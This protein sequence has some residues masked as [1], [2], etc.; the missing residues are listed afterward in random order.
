M[1]AAGRSLLWP[2]ALLLV[3][4][5]NASPGWA[6]PSTCPGDCNGDGQVMV[7]ELITLVNIAL[8][9]APLA[10]C[11]AGDVNR[12]GVIT[13]DDVV[14]AV[15]AALNGCPPAL[16]VI[17]LGT[18]A[19]F[20]GE[21]VNLSIM[22][23]SNGH[24]TLSIA[25]LVF[26]FE[27]AALSV[28]DCSSAVLG[29]S[30]A[31]QQLASGQTL[32]SLSGGLG[33]IADGIVLLCRL[34]IADGAAA[35]VYPLRFTS[36]A[37]LD[38]DLSNLAAAGMDG[39]VTVLAQMPTTSPTLTA[40]AS[41]PPSATETPPPTASR[42]ATPSASPTSS[43]T[44]PATPSPTR[45]LTGTS[46][47][48]ATRTRTFTATR[49]PTRT[50]TPT[51]T[52]SST[53]TRTSTRTPTHTV[54]LTP[55]RTA[56]ATQTQPPT[57]TPTPTVRIVDFGQ[58]GVGDPGGGTTIPFELQAGMTDIAQV[59]LRM[60]HDDTVFELFGCN[61]GVGTVILS[62]AE[63]LSDTCPLGNTTGHVLA[64]T[65]G[66]D[67]DNPIPDGQFLG[68]TFG[69]SSD[70]ALG[71]YPVTFD[72]DLL[73]GFGEVIAHVQSSGAIQVGEQTP[74]PTATPTSFGP[75]VVF[76]GAADFDGCYGCCAAACE[77][78]P[79][80]TPAFDAEGHRIFVRNS[81]QFALIVEGKRGSSNVAVGTILIP[82]NSS[83][84]PDLQVESTNDLGD[85]S[86]AA[87]DVAS[88]G[89][90]PGINP[91]D[92]GPGQSITNALRDFACRFVFFPA[93]SACTKVDKTNAFRTV[94]PS[95]THQFCDF[96]TGIAL[97]PE[98]DSLVTAQLRDKDG[99]LGQPAQIII[100]VMPPP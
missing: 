34:Q 54:T 75:P 12:D 55:T 74:T 38:E 90:V 61:T 93:N 83:L 77:T 65:V 69:I 28:L 36:A 99:N 100:R 22:Q 86:L 45:T 52:L 25:A 31:A 26:G 63:V 59:E 79:T 17:S 40:T 94:E 47:V 71:S 9:S 11:R 96:V 48:T 43:L 10:D 6:Q 15:N 76:L 50:R 60:C 44:P 46:T 66:G 56:T 13:V 53:P 84:R 33:V 23:A 78:T 18:A 91:P 29:K 49:S 72:A 3:L 35:G 81:G 20:P 85:G 58:I 62:D 64:I 73:D 67:N 88:G 8:G 70:A 42:T 89:G 82:A 51:R 14:S 7:G 39:S 68:C 98:G 37:L 19:G 1:C 97:F 32:V 5:V 41:P 57:V 21:T 16:P 92:F 30:A 24:H 95:A 2:V 87:C 27:G 4:Q 80:P